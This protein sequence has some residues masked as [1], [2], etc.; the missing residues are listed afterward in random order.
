MK[1]IFTTVLAYLFVCC[2]AFAAPV[3]KAS[4]L[5][6]AGEFFAKHPAMKGSSSLKVAYKSARH[7]AGA[8]ESNLLYVVNRG[9]DNGYVIVSG[10]DRVMPILAF[11]DNGTLA[12]DRMMQNPGVK[13]MIEEYERQISWAIEHMADRPAKMTARKTSAYEI[14]INPLLEYDNDRV[15]RLP[16]AISWGQ[17]WPFNAYAPSIRYTN[18][19][20]AKTVA[21]CVATGIATVMRWHKWPNKAVGSTTYNWNGNAMSLNWDGNGSENAAYD[22]SNMP[23]AVTSGGV[24]RA[25]GR[26]CT[27]V[28]ADNIG[29]LLRDVGYAVRMGYGTASQGGSGTQVSYWPAPAVRN[30]GYRDGV[31]MLYRANYTTANWLREVRAEM[32]DNGPVIYAG[33]TP[34]LTGGHCFVLDGWATNGYVHVDWGWNRMENGWYLLDV[35]EPG[36]QGIGGHNAG[37]S[38]SQQMVRNFIPERPV[39]P[40]PQPQPAVENGSNLYISSAVSN[41][42]VYLENAQSIKVRLGNRNTQAAYNGQLALAIYK[43]GETNAS[44]IATVN[45]QIAANTASKEITFTANLAERTAGTY[46]L[47]VAYPNGNNYQVINSVAG[48]IILSERPAPQPDPVVAGYQLYV[49]NTTNV[50]TTVATSTKVSV[51][52]RNAG[53]VDYSD[54][55]YLYALP[56]T[57]TSL[58]NATVI[59]SGKGTVAAGRSVTFAF[60]TNSTF[61]QLA[62]G[63][64]RLILAHMKDG[65]R[66]T[67][68][69]ENQNTYYLGTMTINANTPARENGDVQLYTAYFYQNGKELGS[70]YA[71]VSKYNSSNVTVRHYLYSKNGF[72]GDVRAFVTSSGSS[73]SAL[74]SSLEVTK[75]IEIQAGKYVYFDVTYPNYYFYNSNYYVKLASKE[76]GKDWIYGKENVP[77][78]VTSSYNEYKNDGQAYEGISWGPVYDVKDNANGQGIGNDVDDAE[79]NAVTAIEKVEAKAKSTEMFNLNGQRVGES[80]K[81]VVIKD[82]KKT[83]K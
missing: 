67:V 49:T 65:A 26:R 46:N 58:S 52:V 27:D 83:V 70:D 79:D 2:G 80:Y 66:M 32:N 17:D 19:T 7:S 30:F 81:G 21:G 15:T 53:N 77:F 44:I 20:T 6:L 47:V 8:T 64:Y 9:E 75:Q 73:E 45:A 16:Q 82:G 35:L 37:Y 69:L 60:Y 14:E 11:A 56:S 34:Q 41:Q 48:S 51:S 4:A 59:S 42:Q 78:S 33:F 12:E 31:R 18:G 3:D 72:K 62:A 5:K 38:R 61:N 54:N 76:T 68:T 29:R 50:T 39:N 71:K 1:N 40:D 24:N 57:T 43:A 22:W 23:A 28:E 63:S 13:W 10:D 74:N 25:T 55:L 36:Q